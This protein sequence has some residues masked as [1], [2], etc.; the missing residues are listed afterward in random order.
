MIPSPIPAALPPMFAITSIVP[1]PSARQIVMSPVASLW[2]SVWRVS[3]LILT[4]R[5]AASADS[6]FTS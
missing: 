1:C 6:I 3:A 2:R 4:V 5:L